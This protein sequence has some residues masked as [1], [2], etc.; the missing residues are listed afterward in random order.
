[1]GFTNQFCNICNMMITRVCS[2][3]LTGLLVAGCGSGSKI[4]PVSGTVT[5][6]GKPLASAHVAFQPEAPK[7]TQNAGV[8]SYGV[9]D[10]AGKYT[11]K[12]V[13]TDQPGAVVGTHR[14]E[15]NI[16]AEADDRDPKLRAPPKKLPPK[17]NLQSE[18]QFKVEGSGTSAANFDLKSQ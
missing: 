6:E 8:G 10:A 9:T 17:Y 14:V 2:I 3:A 11:L 18:L 7:G 1:L 13:D 12:I 4:V 5:L 15:I 16:K